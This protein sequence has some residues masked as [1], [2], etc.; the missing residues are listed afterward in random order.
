MERT[1]KFNRVQKHLL[2]MFG[3]F[4]SEDTL[5]ELRGVLLKYYAEK[6]Q[7]SID[8]FWEQNMNE[9]SFDQILSENM[10]TPYSR[11]K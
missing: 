9:E 5:S 11:A 6:A 3:Y 10:R 2:Q 4:Q 8:E 7:K 1:T